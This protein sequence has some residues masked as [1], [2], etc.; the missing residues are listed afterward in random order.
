MAFVECG[1]IRDL[2]KVVDISLEDIGYRCWISWNV[3]RKP[4]ASK[5]V[6]FASFLRYYEI[7]QA[8]FYDMVEA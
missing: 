6:K 8:L 1:E 7:T 4:D 2:G 5:I 3:L